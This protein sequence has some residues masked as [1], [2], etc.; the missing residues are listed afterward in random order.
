[1]TLRALS[2]ALLANLLLLGLPACASAPPRATEA[3][4]ASPIGDDLGPSSRV[5]RVQVAMAGAGHAAH[6]MPH[7]TSAPIQKAHEGRDDAHA[8]GTVNK[9]DASSHKLNVSHDPIPAIGWPAMTM[10]FAV[11]PS[12]DLSRIKPGSKINFSLGKDKAGMYQIESVQP[13]GH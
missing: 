3:H 1:M 7:M 2:A 13:A 8:T 11:D 5:P 10:D 4:W 9:V 6:V 12:V